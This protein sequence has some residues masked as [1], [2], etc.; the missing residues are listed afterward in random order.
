MAVFVSTPW[1]YVS[2]VFNELKFI[3]FAQKLPQKMCV[4]I[5]PVARGAYMQ[6]L[7]S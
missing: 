5:I 1:P 6:A 2:G 3:Y 4:F 7:R